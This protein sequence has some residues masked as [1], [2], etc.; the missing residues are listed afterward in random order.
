MITRSLSILFLLFWGSFPVFGQSFTQ[1]SGE[2]QLAVASNGNGVAVAD[3]D[4]D[5][6]LDIFFV[7]REAYDSSRTTTVSRLFRNDDGF[8]VDVTHEAGVL[9]TTNG[10]TTGQMGNQFGAAWGDYD[11][12]G[13]PDL[14]ISQIGPDLLFRN[15]RNGTF[16][17]VAEQMGVRGSNHNSN[18]SS[19]M[20]WD[21]DIDGDLDLYV[22]SW[23]GVNTLFQ[24]NGESFDDVS[25]E[26]GT[27]EPGQTWT[28]IPL[29]VNLDQHP[30]LYVVNDFGDNTLLLSNRDGTFSDATEAYDLNDVGHGMGV[31]IGD[32]NNDGMFDI[33]L[34]NDASYFPNPLFIGYGSGPFVDNAED[35][36]VGDAGWAWGTEFLDY[37]NDRDQDLYVVNGFPVAPG[38]NYLFHNSL[39][40]TGTAGFSDVSTGSGTDGTPDARGLVV[41]DYDQ[42]GR[43]D[44][45]V[46]NW[47]GAPYLY[48]NDTENTGNWI[49]I[50]LQGTLSNRDG[51]GAVVS[52]NIDGQT[53][54][55]HNDG[56]EFLGQSLAPVH[57]GLGDAEVI[58][59]I[60]VS[61]PSGLVE[62]FVDIPANQTITVTENVEV[63]ASE[64]ELLPARSFGID[65]VYPNPLT[66]TSR[67]EFVAAVKQ[68][69]TLE[70]Y[71]V[72]GKLRYSR[73]IAPGTRNVEIN[74]DELGTS[75]IYLVWIRSGLLTA[76]TRLVVL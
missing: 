27:A 25:V 51:L 36:G 13:F 58:D 23:T 72:V 28:S 21:Y 66:T 17:E 31:T 47:T 33:Y 42:D 70:I 56:V 74:R 45:L 15:N 16:D 1:V 9:N 68:G 14:F 30:D 24:N 37:D 5:G 59:Q 4:Q 64:P 48:R 43:L 69:G 6:D 32:C 19:A 62:K 67:I 18:H 20:W 44:L 41:F 71:D 26:S 29:D 52:V 46:S 53:M 63:T 54:Y 65:A 49:Y 76:S 3:Y 61:W 39:V 38:T 22:S 11:N 60:T 10:Y 12:D 7:A 55:R 57:F 73:T 50:K 2:S 8:F 75:G 40:E 34:T 35:L